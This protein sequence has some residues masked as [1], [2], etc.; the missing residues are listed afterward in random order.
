VN[1]K[2]TEITM[3]TLNLNKECGQML[4]SGSEPLPVKQASLMTGSNQLNR[5]GNVALHKNMEEAHGWK[6][7]RAQQVVPAML[8]SCVGFFSV[9][10]CRTKVKRWPIFFTISHCK[11]S[12][13]KGHD[14]LFIDYFAL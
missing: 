11:C 1:E 10:H 8:C 13:V 6:D 4:N 7:W 5:D 3:A 2:I 9:S 14:G 12:Q